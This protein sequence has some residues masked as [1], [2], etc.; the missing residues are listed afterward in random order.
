MSFSPENPDN[1]TE[2]YWELMSAFVDGEASDVEASELLAHLD[3]CAACAREFALLEHSLGE[4]AAIEAVE[5]PA[6][7]RSAILSATT[8]RPTFA[9]R[10][11]LAL[12][13]R[14]LGFGA[15]AAAIALAYVA[16]RPGHLPTVS[17]SVTSEHHIAEL[18]EGDILKAPDR[19]VAD[20]TLSRDAPTAVRAVHSVR[21]SGVHKVT[22][23]REVAAAPTM[24]AS[25]A[26]PGHIGSPR[27][28]AALPFDPTDQPARFKAVELE[29]TQPVEPDII[30]SV[31]DSGAVIN[32]ARAK[33]VPTVA[34]KTAEVTPQ[35]P[36]S[37]L[38]TEENK[39]RIRISLA[40]GDARRTIDQPSYRA[41]KGDG[42]T[43]VR[44][45]F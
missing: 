27:M 2:K 12:T 41:S 1:C 21:R 22:S 29:A 40:E 11:R 45:R 3:S 43:L 28:L 15:A 44:G 42:L 5:A 8:R 34:A 20:A 13:V 4:M 10:V 39:S 19:A 38:L 7:L 32:L 30:V 24:V 14:P 26:R 25:A 16:L 6:R 18:N 33:D 17:P 36:E 31:D 9:D 37:T 35:R 23:T